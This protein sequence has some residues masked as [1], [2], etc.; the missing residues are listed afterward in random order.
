MQDNNVKIIDNLSTGN[1]KYLKV[2]NHENLTL[3]KKRF[4]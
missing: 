4:E 2:V 3:I 1:I